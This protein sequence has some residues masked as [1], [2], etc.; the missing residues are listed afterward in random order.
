MEL[1]NN[2][3]LAYSTTIHPSD[4]WESVL[5]NLK[6]YVPPLK[7]KLSPDQA[8]GIGLRLSNRESLEL[9]QRN[10]L[11]LFQDFLI[12]RGLYVCTMNGLAYGP[13]HK[14]AVKHKLHAPDW[15]K[16]Q[17]VRYTLRLVGILA[18]LLPEGMEGSILTT[19]LSYK[20]WLGWEVE[21]H[22]WELLTR[23]V[24]EVATELVRLYQ[25]QGKLIHL[26]IKPE[27]EGLIENSTE[28][29]QFYEE[30]L[31][32]FGAP[33]LAQKLE[34]S[35]E[36][37]E[38]HLLDHIRFCWDTSQSAIAYERP[39]YVLARLMASGIKVGKI[40]VSSAIKAF[41]PEK[42]SRRAALA[43]SLRPFAEPTYLHQVIQR[44]KSG[45]IRQYSDLHLAL[46]E[47]QNRS[48]TEWRINF[49]LP[50]F[51]EGYGEFASTQEH[52][53][54][55]LALLRTK[56]FTRH[57]EIESYTWDVLPANLK[58]PLRESIRRE[59]EWVLSM[60]PQ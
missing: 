43:Q 15:R 24:V 1:K 11:N 50:L 44:N 29:V 25:T 57:L 22:T 5:T 3:H 58:R 4:G 18:D 48:A 40:Q 21:E 27:A 35:V 23:H 31:L 9:L 12:R 51:I 32:P 16:R 56:S 46:A 17:R 36:Q 47:I 38:T 34:I 2:L 13:F 55:I 49:R 42:R 45:R 52:I 8:F 37:A 54:Q 14:R 60:L 39:H 28:L 59:F 19:P 10:R 53:L 6:Q 41:L 20:P 30:W 26:D 33:I 7:A